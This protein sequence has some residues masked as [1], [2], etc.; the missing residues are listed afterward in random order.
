MLIFVQSLRS[1]FIDV[2]TDWPVQFYCISISLTLTTLELLMLARDHWPSIS[3]FE[4]ACLPSD[5]KELI[6][7][8]L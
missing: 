8:P 7:F 3:E 4:A 1:I 5:C 6:W 2:P